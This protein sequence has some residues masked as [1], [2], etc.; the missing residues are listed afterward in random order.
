MSCNCPSPTA[1]TEVPTSDCPFDLKQVQRVAFQRRGNNFDQTAGTPTNITLGADWAAFKAA[2]DSSKIVCSPLIG[3]D[4]IIDAGEAITEGG[5]DN[6]TLNGVEEVTGTNPSSFSCNFKSITP[7]QEVA[8][9]S[10]VCEKSLMVYLINQDQQIACVEVNPS[11][12]HTGLNIQS[13]F[14]SDRDN[15]GFGT[16]DTNSMSFQLPAGWSENIVLIQPEAGFN[17]LTDL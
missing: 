5:G 8:L 15:K 10:L 9:K 11:D 2:A 16:N 6:S 3:G 13:F 1:L 17:P 14:F 7:L 12:I 4:P